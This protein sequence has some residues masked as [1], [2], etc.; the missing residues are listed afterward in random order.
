V[1]ARRALF[2]DRDGTL[3]VDVHYPKDPAQ[4]EVIPGAAEALRR[5]QDAWTLVVVSNQSGIGRGLITEAQ[6]AAVHDRFVAAFA[7]AGVRFEG[8]Y[9]CPHLPDAGCACRKPAP[10]ML[11]DAAREL[12]L[13]LARSAMLGDKPSDLEAGRAAGCAHV[14]R[15]GPDAD[16]TAADAR[17]ED[18][19]E[20]VEWL[21]SAER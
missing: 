14:L 21:A 16:G 10:G 11:V 6:A 9:Y 3:I 7:A 18:W 4:V 15:F 8:C 5:L 17:C 19:R 2:L 20:V 12:G 1:T 13:D